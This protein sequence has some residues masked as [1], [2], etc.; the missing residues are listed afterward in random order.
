MG[1]LYHVEVG[2]MKCWNCYAPLIWNADFT[3]ED[4]GLEGEGIVTTLSCSKCKA[5]V[6]VHL[7]LGEED[8]A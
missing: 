8:E 3:Y 2:K 7:P 1:T 4:Y 6:E 5:D